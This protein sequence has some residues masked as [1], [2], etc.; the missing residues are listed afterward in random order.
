MR[1]SRIL[2]ALALGI[3]VLLPISS[4]PAQAATCGGNIVVLTGNYKGHNAI[5]VDAGGQFP[6]ITSIYYNNGYSNELVTN[7]DYGVTYDKQ[8]DKVGRY[9]VYGVSTRWT[10]APSHWDWRQNWRWLVFYNC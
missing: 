7:A 4:V 2:F 9:F 1:K 8:R 10:W 3:V 5:Y 6:A